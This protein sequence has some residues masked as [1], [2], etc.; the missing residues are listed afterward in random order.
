MVTP[1]QSIRTKHLSIRRLFDADIPT[2]ATYRNLPE[3]T[4]MQLWDSFNEDKAR[5][6]IEGMAKLEPFTAGDSFQFGVELVATGQLIGDLYFK[7]DEAG[8]QAELGYSFDPQF[9]KQGLATEATRALLDHAFRVIGLHRIY[10][11]TDPR[12]TPSI[13]L[14][15]RLGM[16]Q[17]AHFRKNL[18][19]KGE[20]ADDVVFAVLE[21]EW[22]SSAEKRSELID[23]S[24]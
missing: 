23:S 10:G 5:A 22:S 11:I 9:Q 2:L 14:M 13:K 3:V 12:N 6:L 21:E 1:F 20:W 17:E 8:K 7:M 4:C 19:F 18:W 16:R 15:Q 24:L